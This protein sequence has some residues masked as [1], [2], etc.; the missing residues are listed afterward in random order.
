VAFVLG[1]YP[2]LS[3]SFVR[4]ELAHLER[5]G[6][7]LAIVVCARAS[8]CDLWLDDGLRAQVFRAD[9]SAPTPRPG[10]SAPRDFVRRTVRA[11]RLFSGTPRGLLRAA[12][13]ASIARTIGPLLADWR[14][15]CLHAHFLGMPAV[16]GCLLSDAIGVPLSLSAH[17]RD[18]FVPAVRFGAVC[19]RARFVAACSK[20][21]HAALAASLPADIAAHI[22]DVPHGVPCAPERP[23]RPWRGGSE[24]PV[25]LLSVCRLVPKKGIDVLLRALPL[26]GVDVPLHYRVVG[27]GPELPR[28]RTLA[29]AA[30][31]GAV[32]FVG[33]KSPSDVA[34]E[35]SAA[36]LFVLAPRTAPDGDRDGIP[37]A[38]LE[39][40][41]AGLPVVVSD[42]GG[43]SE[44]V[45]DRVTGWMTPPDN[46][47]ALAAAI[48]EA[49]F[50]DS[51]RRAITQRAHGEVRRRFSIDRNVGALWCLLNSPEDGVDE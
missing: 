26:V 51:L 15:D 48:R 37:N 31:P 43:V 29:R 28:L 1:Q 10:F 32:E 8:S 39:A 7:A 24:G 33:A 5:R 2:C 25:R 17:A 23:S 42:A 19:G 47:R 41:A 21:A 22:V 14:P 12:R 35:F 49:V 9:R 27:D 11:S 18:V 36:D 16:V 50:D 46:P 3:E 34:A 6:V 4:R 13:A 38:V 45:E 40:M 30:G 20:H 44:V